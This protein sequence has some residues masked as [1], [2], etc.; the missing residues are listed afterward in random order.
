MIRE[1]YINVGSL[2]VVFRLFNASF[3]VFLYNLVQLLESLTLNL[4]KKVQHP[5][6]RKAGIERLQKKR[7]CQNDTSLKEDII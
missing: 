1:I 4:Y 5:S 7:R 3:F 6:N 2:K